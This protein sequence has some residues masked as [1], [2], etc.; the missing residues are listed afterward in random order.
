MKSNFSNSSFCNIIKCNGEFVLCG[1]KFGIAAFV[2][3]PFPDYI[4]EWNSLVRTM[5]SFEKLRELSYYKFQDY[6]LI[7]CHRH[8]QNSISRVFYQIFHQ[9]TDFI[10]WRVFLISVCTSNSKLGTY[11]KLSTLSWCTLAACKDKKFR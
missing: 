3:M 7:Y 10:F 6:Q 9:M 5:L 11:L 1:I 4:W 8:M 2:D